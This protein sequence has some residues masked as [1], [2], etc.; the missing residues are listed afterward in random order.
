ML[1]FLLLKLGL[2]TSSAIRIIFMGKKKKIMQLS[3]VSLKR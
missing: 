3:M 1:F 2:K